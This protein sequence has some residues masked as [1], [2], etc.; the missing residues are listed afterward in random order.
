MNDL[1]GHCPHCERYTLFSIGTSCTSNGSHYRWSIGVCNHCQKAILIYET[2]GEYGSYNTD[3]YYPSILPKPIPE[4]IPDFIKSDLMEDHL[5]IGVNAFRASAVLSRRI[6]QMICI[7]KGAKGE[8][9]ADQ[10]EELR[11][12]GIITV[13]I[14]EWAHSVRWVG[15]NAAHPTSSEVSK[16]DAEDILN[17]VEQMI[18]VLYVAT[19]LAKGKKEKFAPKKA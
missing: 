19:K 1:S 16:E 9:L 7:D 5:C 17:L 14:A 2:L 12:K 11:Q 18:H 10:I 3:S 13:D 15:N 6:L 4:N 8:K